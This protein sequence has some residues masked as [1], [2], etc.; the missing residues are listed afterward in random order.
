MSDDTNEEP[1]PERRL[2]QKEAAREYRKAAYKKAKAYH[3]MQ[4]TVRDEALANN[5]ELMA[6]LLAR[7]N[8]QKERARKMRS[9]AYAKVKA[10]TKAKKVAEK[11]AIRDQ[12]IRER[13]EERRQKDAELWEAVKPATK[14]PKL[15]LVK[16]GESSEKDE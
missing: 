1:L 8:E 2:T 15:R 4:K 7:K 14:F 16:A 9:E 5:P 10:K 3:K 11:D 6:K 13:D 12:Q